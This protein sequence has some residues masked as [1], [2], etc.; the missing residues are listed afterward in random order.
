MAGAGRRRVQALAIRH[1]QRQIGNMTI[2]DAVAHS[3][4]APFDTVMGGADLRMI[5]HDGA[6]P[7]DLIPHVERALAELPIGLLARLVFAYPEAERPTVI[8]NLLRLAEQWTIP[9]I[10]EW[11]TT[12]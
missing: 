4:S 3:A 10:T 8:N 2:F 12:G 1:Y 7:A 9:R 5:L 6:A 11:L